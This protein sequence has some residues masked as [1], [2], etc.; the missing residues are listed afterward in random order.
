M[1]IDVAGLIFTSPALVQDVWE[2][3]KDLLWN[4]IDV[5]VPYP[6]VDCGPIVWELVTQ[7][8]TAIDAA[9]FTPNT[10][11]DPRSVSV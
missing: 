1:E 4:D 5:T 7:T 10:L 6:G 8:D 2:P 11:I 3:A 9:V